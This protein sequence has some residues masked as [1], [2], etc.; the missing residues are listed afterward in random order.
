MAN[1]LQHIRRVELEPYHPLG[2]GK[3]EKLGKNYPLGDI[4]FPQDSEVQT[5]LEAVR[6]LTKVE[7][8]K[9]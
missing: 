3:S 5:W 4:R 7:V 6:A 2:S 8:I 1:G 9:S